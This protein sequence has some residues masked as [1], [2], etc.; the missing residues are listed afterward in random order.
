MEYCEWCKQ[1]DNKLTKHMSSG[2]GITYKICSKCLESA[3]EDLCRKCDQ[4]ILGK[5]IA[6]LCVDCAQDESAEEQKKINEIA[7]GVNVD[8]LQ[9]YTSD[10][11]FT[12]KDYERWVVLS[13]KTYTREEIKKNRLAWLKNKLSKSKEWTNERIERNADALAELIDKYSSNI[14]QSSYV[15]IYYPEKPEPGFKGKRPT[16]S[17]LDRI[18]DVILIKVE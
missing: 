10:L 11:V 9:E 17:I 4:I 8:L 16:A 14:L 13:Q 6:G 1:L 2:T 7:E 5:D 12:E 18:G 15:L 3:E